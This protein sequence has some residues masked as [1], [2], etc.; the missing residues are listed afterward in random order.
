MA[1]WIVFSMVLIVHMLCA[2]TAGKLLNAKRRLGIAYPL[3]LLLEMVPV[4]VIL[5]GC[6][7]IAEWLL[8]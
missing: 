4:G 6:Y 5:A 2:R 1:F 8:R 3:A 7:T